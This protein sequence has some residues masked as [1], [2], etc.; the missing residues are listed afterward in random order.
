MVFGRRA[1]ID[2]ARKK[3]LEYLQPSTRTT[4]LQQSSSGSSPP[5]T[6]RS[7][8]GGVIS[9]ENLVRKSF[10]SLLVLLYLITLVMSYHSNA[11]NLYLQLHSYL[12]TVT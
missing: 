3:Y 9:A 8:G 5:V 2:R 11:L 4:K 12:S 10:I 6:P 7:R 1:A